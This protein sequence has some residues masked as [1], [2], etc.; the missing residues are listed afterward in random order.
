MLLD[1]PVLRQI[2]GFVFFTV[3]PGLLILYL[4]GLNKLRLVERMVLSVGCSVFFLMVFGLF[5]NLALHSLGYATPLSTKSVIISFSVIILAFCLIAYWKNREAFLF[6]L[7]EFK[8]D[9]KEK[10]ILLIPSFFLIL[11]IYGAY[12]MNTTSNNTVLLVLLFMIA[13]YVIV[14]AAVNRKM[15]E[16]TY[17]IIIFSM[18]LSLLLMFALRSNHIMGMDAHY[19]FYLFQ[20]TAAKQYWQVFSKTTLDSCLSISLLPAIYQ[21]IVNIDAEYLFKML[22]T[23]LLSTLPLVVYIICRRYVSGLYAFLASFFFISVTMFIFTTAL[24]RTNMAILF[25]G[26]V[27]MVIVHDAMSDVS[28]KVLVLAFITSIVLSHYSATYIT[29]FILLATW[30]G[31]QAFA[32]LMR[33]RVKHESPAP[34]GGRDNLPSSAAIPPAAEANS[35]LRTGLHNFAVSRQLITMYTVVLLFVIVFL[36]YSQITTSP[37]EYGVR[38]V[39]GTFTELQGFFL[40]ESRATTVEMAFGQRTGGFPL[41]VRVEQISTWATIVLIA[42]GVL[43]A[44]ARLA[45]QFVRRRSRDE[46][47]WHFVMGIDAEYLIFS[48]ACCAIMVASV[49][50]P[51]ISIHYSMGRQY[52]QTMT[53]LSLFL[54]VGSMVIAKYV[55]VKPYWILIPVLI[56]YF[57]STSGVTHQISGIPKSIW[58]N[59][60]GPLYDAWYVSDEDS[61]AAKWLGNYSSQ[62]MLVYADS[63]TDRRLLSQ[64]GIRPNVVLDSLF[65][66]DEEIGG[67]IYYIYLRSYN[68][69]N[70]KMLYAGQILDMAEIQNDFSGKALI[71]TNSGSEVWR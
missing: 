24:A 46:N 57:L 12:L 64:A 32:S 6:D 54:V 43:F 14:A 42:I 71:Y 63:S 38:F 29:F 5:I 41:P 1:I 52:F 62:N 8:L 17:P 27:V 37:F 65:E 15:S 66:R 34:G 60:E 68:V 3:V 26:L 59:S 7:S 49:A 19:E 47:R 4:L 20:T 9:A 31:I 45:G 56:V 13:A 28:K 40:L 10:A 30:I 67:Y 25:F 51:H 22:Y 33:S 21:S 44:L 48:A 23:L 50:L 53:A 18:G 70:G 35:G 11:S 55:R 36:W 69:V 61:Y 39:K 16:K 58:L 2:A